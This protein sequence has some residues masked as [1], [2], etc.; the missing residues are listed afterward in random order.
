MASITKVW[1]INRDGF[2]N[3][4]SKK[5]TKVSVGFEWEIENPWEPSDCNCDNDYDEFCP[6]CDE[7]YSEAEPNVS[8]LTDS[9]TDT[10][11]FRTHYECGGTEFASP[12][13]R[14]LG[15]ARAM[16]SRIK[17]VAGADSLL[18]PK[19]TNGC[20]IHVHTGFSGWDFRDARFNKDY[21]TVTSMLNR[22]S[23]TPF[24]LV[25]SGRSSTHD[26]FK[27]ARSTG[28]DIGSVS[29]APSEGQL[30]WMR[31]VEMVRPNRF[32]GK[33]T[34]EYRIW[35]G[36]EDR[37]QPAIDFAHACTTFITKRKANSIPYLKEFKAW[38]DKQ[39]GY[40]VLKQDPA[41]SLI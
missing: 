18:Y 16:A 31:H 3:I 25:F 7:E 29:G 21:R 30:D 9:F 8:S 17:A 1:N 4:T 14:N 40:K 22:A 26:Y 5:F 37:L 6:C 36:T 20:G 23:S 2:P 35:N 33:S 24:I 38:V 10:H 34:I 12:V 27:Q 13:F 15:T 32:D 39:A 11:G 19:E 41:W 28:W